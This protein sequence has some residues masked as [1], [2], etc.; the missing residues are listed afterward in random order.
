MVRGVLR[1][2]WQ[3]TGRNEALDCRVYA[4]AALYILNPRWTALKRAL[5]P[6]DETDKP[7]RRPI[8]RKSSGW[9]NRWRD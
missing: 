6:G 4:M 9:V 7:S 3:A 5:T 2:V 1:R 8:R